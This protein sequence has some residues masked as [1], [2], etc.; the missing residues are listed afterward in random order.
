MFLMIENV[1]VAPVEAFTVFGAST[2]RN[3][4][5]LIGMFGSGSKHATL[6][7]LRHHLNP[8]IYSGENR[9]EFF[10]EPMTMQ[11]QTFARVAYRFNNETHRTSYTL[12]FGELDWKN[13]VMGLREYVSNALDATGGDLDMVNIAMVDKAEPQADTTRVFIPVTPE[14]QEFFA[15][16]P[17]YFLQFN[18]HRS[19]E[20]GLLD[21]VDEGRA[22]I[23]RKGVLVRTIGEGRPNSI[24]DY[25]FGDELKIDESR[26][27]DDYSVASAVENLLANT[28]DEKHINLIFDAITS[29]ADTWEKDRAGFRLQYHLNKKYK[30]VFEKRYGKDAVIIKDGQAFLADY[31][32]RKGFR[33]VP[34][35]SDG[36]AQALK[37]VGIRN[38]LDVLEDVND[39]GDILSKPSKEL[40]RNVKRVWSVLEDFDLHGNKQ[41]PRIMEFT[42]RMEAGTQKG[43]Y[44]KGD[45]IFIEKGYIHSSKV[46]L[47][48]L[49]HYITGATDNSRDFQDWAF[50][51]GGILID[52][53]S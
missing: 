48:E 46:I 52:F 19:S 11:G 32:K 7:L 40:L 41:L 21:K 34:V 38:V 1:G 25:N 44:Q 26:N 15:N 6:T 20:I 47:E 36:W 9:L 3:S 17:K 30:E 5:E 33:V 23:Y 53:L 50:K 18:S 4:K 14:V 49:G 31:A 12:E 51:V 8:I 37:H 2:A 42:S 27:L 10:T 29:S 24:F 39:D 45:T 13:I 22:N 28:T 35:F 43:G 16:L